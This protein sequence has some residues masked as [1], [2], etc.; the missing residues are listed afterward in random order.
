MG[1]EPVNRSAYLGGTSEVASDPSIQDQ[2]AAQTDAAEAGSPPR[3]NFI[4]LRAEALVQV[5]SSLL[6]PDT[7]AAADFRSLAQEVE[8]ALHV[9]YHRLLTELKS[10][11]AHFDPDADTLP[12]A[13]GDA[14]QREAQAALLFTEMRWLLSRANFTRLTAR[15]IDEASDAAGEW[16][17]RVRVDEEA[18]DSLEVWGRGD[19]IRRRT[20]RRWR[21]GFRR[22][23]AEFPVYQRLIVMLRLK[24]D[25]DVE[26]YGPPGGIY[27]K[28]FKNI[29][30]RDMNM[31]LPGTRVEMTL[32]DRGRILLPM[33]SGLALTVAKLVQ[34][35]IVLAF[36]SISG[37]LAFLGLVGGTVGYGA[38][39]FFGYLSTRQ[40]YQLNL[41]RSLY[42][43]NL[44]NNAG[45]LFRMLDEAHEQECRETLLAYWMLWQRGGDAG[46]DA[47]RLDQTVEALLRER[48]GL[49][50]DFEIQDALDKLVRLGLAERTSA[51]TYRA[52]P[53]AV[54]RERL[55]QTWHKLLDERDRL[56]TRLCTEPPSGDVPAIQPPEGKQHAVPSP[57]A[58]DRT[59]A[60]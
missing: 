6:G 26:A 35:A 7:A 32:F 27:L 12:A 31:L 10:A 45:V 49:Q 59:P 23:V 17:V 50:V 39:S 21:K 52:D 51:S 29:P 44:D 8:L 24:A 30:R 20:R 2:S 48:L 53:P 57:V 37:L 46:L 38:R 18:F 5:L 42:Y 15:E 22:E 25:S 47:G 60:N 36:N 43:Q 54:A 19:I 58:S 56:L 16:G 41:T 55:A 34:G 9:E 14:A 4:P 40:R 11:Y 3:E 13:P 33:I 28:L 1:R